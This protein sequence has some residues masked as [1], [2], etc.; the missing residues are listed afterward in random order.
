M[1]TG[2]NGVRNTENTWNSTMKRRCNE[3]GCMT[4]DILAQAENLLE[5]LNGCTLPGDAISSIKIPSVVALEACQ[6]FPQLLAEAKRQKALNPFQA[7]VSTAM[8][9]GDNEFVFGDKKSLDLC[10]NMIRDRD[11]WKAKAIE[12]RANIILG[13]EVTRLRDKKETDEIRLKAARELEEEMKH[14]I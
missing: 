10:E 13:F 7:D 4:D 11:V 1:V 8:R 3:R 9:L 12:E 6:M 2:F 14:D 5:R